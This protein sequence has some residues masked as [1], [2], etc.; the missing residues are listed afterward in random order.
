MACV[1]G[2]VGSG[3]TGRLRAG[4]SESVDLGEVGAVDAAGFTKMVENGSVVGILGSCG[5][6]GCR[7]G[8]SGE[9]TE[10]RRAPDRKCV[11][12]LRVLY[13]VDGLGSRSILARDADGLSA[14]L[15]SQTLSDQWD[16]SG[17]EQEPDQ[18][19]HMLL[20]SS[21]RTATQRGVSNNRKTDK[22]PQTGCPATVETLHLCQRS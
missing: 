7:G 14:V 15:A 22:N 17:A 8:R 3:C 18:H 9:L 2:P 1:V 12:L 11:A 10:M 16:N 20:C 6:G 5:G 4:S 19:L 13:P 21:Q